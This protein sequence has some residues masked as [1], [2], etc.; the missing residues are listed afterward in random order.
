MGA[1]AVTAPPGDFVAWVQSQ[2]QSIETMAA[3]NAVASAN[4]PPEAGPDHDELPRPRVFPIPKEE[5]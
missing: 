4:P 5:T 1:M 2:Q 3:V